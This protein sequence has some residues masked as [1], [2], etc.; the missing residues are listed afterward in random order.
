MGWAF[1]FGSSIKSQDD[2]WTPDILLDTPDRTTVTVDSTNLSLALLP[3]DLV[4]FGF[5]GTKTSE[6]GGGWRGR[7]GRVFCISQLM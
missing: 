3:D 6:A 7:Q 1:P 2:V 4:Q 5:L